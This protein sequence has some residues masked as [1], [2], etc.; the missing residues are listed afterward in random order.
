M[1]I[2]SFDLKIPAV[3]ALVLVG[4]LPIS[5]RSQEAPSRA[6]ADAR[7]VGSE[8][9]RELD[10]ASGYRWTTTVAASDSAAPG[11]NSAGWT[12]KHGFTR[13]ALSG[14]PSPLDFV[15]R[16]GKS[17]VL[18][19]GYWRVPSR[20]RSGGQ[21]GAPGGG[22]LRT[23]AGF[24]P[25]VVQAEELLGAA[26]EVRHE[27]D[28]VKAVLPPESAAALLDLEAPTRRGSRRVE[29]PIKGPHG[30]VEFHIVDGLLTEYALTLGGSR[31]IGDREVALDR[32]I[33]TRIVDV[34]VAKVDVPE[35]AREIVEALVAGQE[36]KVFA[37]EDGFRRLFDGRS[38]SG[39]EGRP[40]FWSVEDHAIVG[41]TTKD[42]PTKGNTFLFA[43]SAGANLIV[44]DFELRLAFKITADN[45]TGFANSGIQYRS[46]DR[47]DF[48]AA[49]YQADMEAGP[50]YSGILY[51]EAGGAGGRGIMADRGEKV[52]WTADG[53]KDVTGRLGTS[54]E[55]GAKIKKDD[56]NEYVVIARGNHLQHFTNGVPTVDVYDED[57]AK[58][59][60]S[61][62]LALQLHAGEPMTVRFKDV[63]IKS[64]RSASESAAGNVRVAKGFKL[65]QI[66]SVP[67]ESQGSW[68]ALCVDQK[69]RLI[70]ADQRGKL[71]R[72][73]T[74]PLDRSS[75]V[76]PEAI[77]VDL[78]GAHGLLYAFDSLYV[79]VNEAGTHGLYRVRDTDGDDRYDEVKLLRE[80]KGGG[81]HG[82]HS[83]LLSPDGKSLFVVCGNSTELTKV[84]T[85]RL[86][87]NWGEDNLATRV[88]TGFMDDS[89]APQG[90][91]ARTDPDGKSWELVA[92]GL[93][94]P[95]DLAFNREGEL[96]T[97][98]AD[99]E[100][101]IGEPWYRPTRINHVI[102]G[103]EY[104]FRNGSGKWPAYYIDSFGAVVDI[105]PGSPTGITFGY[106]AKFPKKYEDALFICD[107]SFGKLRA[108]H[109]R[110]DGASYAGEVEEFISGQ[111]LPVTDVVINPKDGAMYLAVGGR[112]AQSALYR[113]TYVGGEVPQPIP[114]QPGSTMRDLRRKLE[115]YH[116]HADAAA[117]DA[118][119]PYL[120]DQDRAIRYAARIA[121]EWQDPATWRT[122]ALKESD[123]R[124]AI[125]AL[126]ALCRDSGKDEPHR[127][128]DDPRP[129]PALQGEILKALDSIDWSS[130]GRMDRV[131]L[132][133]AYALAF[134]RLGRPDE[135][136]ARRLAARLDA[137]F[138]SKAVESDYL[139]AEILSY[140]QAPTA[141][142]KIMAALRDALTQEEKVQYALILRGLKAGWTRP[143]REEYFRWF[144]TE[145]ATF[146]GGNTFASSLQTIKNQ[147]IESLSEEERTALKPI[148]DARPS[149]KSPRDL[150]A[151]RKTVKEWTLAELVPI[152]ERGM[153]EKRDLDRGRRLFGSVACASCHRCGSD[154][155]GVGPDLTA[156]SGR[157]N[158]HDLLE[159]M[160]EPS[161]VISDQYAAVVIAK[162]DG[163]VVTGRV[164][165]VFG[166]TLSV[167]EDMF[168]PGHFTNVKRADIDEM[169]ASPIS[170]MPVGLLSS[171]TEDEIQDLV[172]FLLVRSDARGAP[173]R[174]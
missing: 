29:A 116:G 136:A 48:V 163:Q 45:A 55:I 132:L 5:A 63:R 64:L 152:V 37:P 115:G 78:A 7:L 126:V 106:G 101:D 148:L 164:G 30:S 9:V 1:M 128:A 28:R 15:T 140:L 160:V 66:Y 93:R 22:E 123:P 6:D 111:P 21:A 173:P 137:F 53:R 155:G 76:E 135:E 94:N 8:G 172:A 13:V 96:F 88:P 4:F 99:M 144:V 100:W 129:D 44:D 65:D 32:T 73:T 60:D 107:W 130:L 114:V 169:K 122:K 19:D 146:R 138:P 40:G 90:W 2:E 110:P 120:S 95:F 14:E 54:E 147:A 104:G 72:M 10:E 23:I 38:L 119:W 171:L 59:L 149:T 168:D 134:T 57:A 97:Y 150:L 158:V 108:V 113:V 43:K 86:P 167:V 70:A 68:V 125:A 17:A 52:T 117:I 56:W 24:R 141:A 154:G 161:K 165:N 69:G 85:S 58:R 121:L 34:G 80:I 105:G 67:K 36:P 20:P 81:E 133:R 18:L 51:D 89:L 79:M 156:V 82:M 145:A 170:Q 157:F 83:I 77:G 47:G 61:G 102:S 166:D 35:D 39:W 98:D 174:P 139:L 25:P 151:A 3:A 131:D 62:I 112:G 12:R 84:D 142:P 49:G 74:P 87:L 46:R 26:T 75:E 91:I 109:L 159:S 143:L 27:G 127:K 41:R 33:T 118:A 103:A 153:G 11:R 50:R 16:G 71:Y 42:H 31:R 92:A 162:T 124:K